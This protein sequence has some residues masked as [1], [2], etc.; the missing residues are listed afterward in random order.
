MQDLAQNGM[1]DADYRGMK[2][3]PFTAKSLVGTLFAVA[4]MTWSPLQTRADM[5]ALNSTTSGAQFSS[6]RSTKGWAFTI[7][8]P[9][10]VTQL[11]LWDQGNNGLNASHVVSIWTS[12]GT[13]MAQT[14]IPLGTGATLI[15]G[16]RYVSI[17]S[18]LLP[19]GSYTIGGFYGRSDDRFAINPPT[20]TTASGISYN[21]SRSRGGFAFPQGNFFGNV[22]SYF[23]PN[24]QFTVAVPAPDAGSTVSLLGLALFGLAALRRK[25]SW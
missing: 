23:G 25:L 22:N 5:I 17:T 15:D 12:T 16:F 4:L 10:L 14:T 19:A 13:L 9:V 24:F 20:I 21:G 1:F 3:L 6:E 7:N 2:A 11:G 8:S 18:V